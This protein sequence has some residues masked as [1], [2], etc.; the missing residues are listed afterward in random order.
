V[1]GGVLRFDPAVSVSG[2][3]LKLS[4]AGT[5][6]SEIFGVY[7]DKSSLVLADKLLIGKQSMPIRRGAAELLNEASSAEMARFLGARFGRVHCKPVANIYVFCKPVA[8]YLCLSRK[9]SLSKNGAN[10]H[11]SRK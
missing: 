1:T 2:A 8:I 7:I 9:I 10:R 3:N 4:S 6:A 5:I 11:L